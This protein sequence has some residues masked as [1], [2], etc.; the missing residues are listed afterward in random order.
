MTSLIDIDAPK[1]I[2]PEMFGRDEVDYSRI[3]VR[4]AEFSRM[5]GCSK[6][7]VSR[8]IQ[9]GKVLLGV[10]GRLN[11]GVAVQ[12]LLRNSNPSQIRSKFLKPVL[13]DLDMA[14]KRIREL[15]SLL[16]NEKEQSEF[17]DGANA[18]LIEILELIDTQLSNEL[19]DLAP[20]ATPMV[21]EAFLNWLYQ[22]R[23]NVDRS[24]L[25]VDHLPPGALGDDEEGAGS[26]E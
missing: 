25:I 21:I 20:L 4:P 14:R 26:D 19:D 5:M 11:P 15:E 9:E 16:R 2:Q 8:W 12:Q 24:I 13:V 17:T 1:D 22:Q 18:E 7:A 10:D 23:Q 6:Q 3:R